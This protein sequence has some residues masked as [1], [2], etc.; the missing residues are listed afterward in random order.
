MIV[1]IVEFGGI[2][3]LFDIMAENATCEN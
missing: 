1:F 2:D 3:F